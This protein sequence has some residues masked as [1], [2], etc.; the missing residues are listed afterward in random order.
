MDLVVTGSSGMI[1]RALVPALEVAGHRVRRLVRRE[2]ASPD[3]VRWDPATGTI[4]AAGLAGVDGAVHLAGEGIAE[5]RWTEAQKRRIRESRTAGTRLLAETLATL[6]PRPAVLLS[7]SAVG[8][9]GDGGEAVLT[10]ASPHGTGFLSDVVMAWE[11]ATRPASDAGIR[12]VLLRTGLVLSPTGGV[13]AKTL[14]LF[15]LGVGGP[16]GRGHEWWPWIALDDEVGAIVHLLT[17]DVAGPVN[18]TA[19]VPV[20]NRDYTKALGR[21][22]HRPTLVPVPRFAPALLLGRE[23]ARALLGDSQRIEPQRLLASGY[24][25][26]HPELD[27]ALRAMFT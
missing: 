14:P 21:A 9:Y 26:R 16:I 10:E 4:D 1:G 18:L 11:E 17:A 23:L 8:Y 19:P 5:H 20:R 13:M 6:D 12:T 3:E 15:K 24:S 27:G 7:G 25:F 22:L 2:P